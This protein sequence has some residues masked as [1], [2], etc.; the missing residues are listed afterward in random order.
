MTDKNGQ[1]RGGRRKGS[2]RPKG[3]ISEE[4]RQLLETERAYKKRA[5]GVADKLLNAQLALALGE[6]NLFVKTVRGNKT[7]TT[8]VD[9]IETVKQYLSGELEDSDNEYYYL[10]TKN[11][12]GKAIDSIL[13]RTY[14]KARQSVD[15]TS[16]DEPLNRIQVSQEV[17]DSFQEFMLEKTKNENPW[18]S[19]EQ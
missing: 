7:I 18:E 8:M 9:D 3:S 19:D 16:D 2:G 15:I 11:P 1:N 10:A 6:I 12:D 13:D 14:G 17:L 5:A 4:K